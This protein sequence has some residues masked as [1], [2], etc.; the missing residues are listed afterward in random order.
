MERGGR[1]RNNMDAPLRYR[2]VAGIL[3]FFAFLAV[4][5]KTV[6]PDFYWHLQDG[7]AILA[8]HMVPR[9]DTYS[10]TMA[11]MPWVDHE[12]L[13]EAGFAWM[14]NHNLMW[15]LAIIFAIIA[16]IPF[17]V[18]LKRYRSWPALWAIAAGATLFMSFLAIR[19]QILPYLLFF[20]VS[21]CSPV[22]TGMGRIARRGRK[23]IF[24]SC[25]SSFLYGRT[26]THSLS[27]DSRSSPYSC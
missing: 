22:T 4:I 17:V 20:I 14:W 6:D 12:W 18:W 15:A 23:Y 8:T 25:H 9:V 2:V 19:P 1:T 16:F 24:W 13:V 11:N 5:A 21:S 7:E 27:R 10:F 26:F 3:I